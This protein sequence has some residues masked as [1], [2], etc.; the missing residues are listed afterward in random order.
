MKRVLRL[1][2]VAVLAF[3][4]IKPSTFGWRFWN[5]LIMSPTE[6][7]VGA[8][9][10]LKSHVF[11]LSAEIGDRSIFKPDKLQEAA[12]YIIEQFESYGYQVQ[13]QEYT[14]SNK[15]VKNIIVQKQGLKKPDEIIIVGAHYDTCFNPG[16]NDNASAVAG[17]LELARCLSA[18]PTGSTVKFIAFVNEEPP[19]FKTRNMGSRVYARSAR[20]RGENIKAV[21]VLEMIGYYSNRPNSQ[22]YPP[23]FGLFYPNQAN[24]ICVVSNFRCRRLAKQVTSIFRKKTRFP[25]EKVVAFGFVSG[26]DF[27]DHY[28]FWKEGYPAVMIT[29]TAFYRYSHY[30]QSTDT[31][32]KLDYN[33][34]AEVIEGL[35]GVI[36]EIA[37]G[38]VKAPS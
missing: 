9:E 6:E 35:K 29:D 22:R 24:F 25:I 2:I 20:A 1:I 27:S 18:R 12:G 8:A 11:K 34:M 10:L 37:G 36:M 19:F 7:T 30:H 14:V 21:L 15:I 5:N 38:D 28:S 33:S 16:A 13:L 23:F 4:F 26:I 32:E 3:I 17:L 31:Y